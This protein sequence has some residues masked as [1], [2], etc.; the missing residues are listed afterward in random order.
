MCLTVL[1]CSHG[2]WEEPLRCVYNVGLKV[3][4]GRGARA[5][6]YFGMFKHTF[7]HTLK[8]HLNKHFNTCLN[9]HCE[10]AL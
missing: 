1:T 6:C 3:A 7:K 8:T 5:L 2:V 4:L 9:K 10:H